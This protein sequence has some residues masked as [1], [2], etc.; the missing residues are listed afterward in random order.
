MASVHRG[1]LHGCA[2]CWPD[3]TGC[4]FDCSAVP[5]LIGIAPSKV[6][7]SFFRFYANLYLALHVLATRCV[8]GV[9]IA[10]FA[11]AADID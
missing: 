9:D 8:N 10:D 5:L 3:F 1:F 4:S 6:L 11:R 7:T 2:L